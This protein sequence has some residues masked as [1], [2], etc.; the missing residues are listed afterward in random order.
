MGKSVLSFLSLLVLLNGC[1]P[2]PGRLLLPD[3]LL[4][5][6]KILQRMRERTQG[7][8]TLSGIARLAIQ[9]SQGRDSTEEV[10]LLQPPDAI[11]LESWN[12]M[13][14]L[15][16]LMISK[17]KKGVFVVPGE[18]KTYEFASEPGP[19]KRL[20]GLDLSIRDL[21]QILMGAPP[22]P[23]LEPDQILTELETGGTVLEILQGS[24]VIQ[25]VWIDLSGRIVRWERLDAKGNPMESLVFDDFQEVEGISMPF[26]IAYTGSGGVELTLRYRSLLLNQSIEDRLF[27]T[28][29]V[30]E[31]INHE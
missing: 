24:R 23:P 9:T 22:I 31:T 21:L 28:S 15:Q 8:H 25:K 17:G 12:S 6:Q 11:R 29:E 20:L 7:I 14:G 18:F 16:L 3:Q 19:L 26:H 27:D 13:G 4:M 10:I 30:M 1:V 2:T 5:H